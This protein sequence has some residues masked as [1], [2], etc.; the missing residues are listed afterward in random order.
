MTGTQQ[1]RFHSS[2]PVLNPLKSLSTY[3]VSDS[4][5]LIKTLNIEFE[6]R[7]SNLTDFYAH[8]ALPTCLCE[9]RFD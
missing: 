7:R 6:V 2:M 3:S 1:S 9:L 5:I 8:N 4:Q